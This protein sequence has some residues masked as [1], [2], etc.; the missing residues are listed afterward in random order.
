MNFLVTRTIGYFLTYGLPN[1]WL[2]S[3][4]RFTKMT[5]ITKTTKNKTTQ[6]ATNN[7]SRIGRNHGNHR[8]DKNHRNPGKP[9]VPPK[10]GFEVPE[11][12]GRKVSTNFFRANVEHLHRSGTWWQNP[13]TSHARSLFFPQVSKGANE[14]STEGTSFSMPSPSPERPTPLG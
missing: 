14:L 8:H 10:T 9:R 13:R 2:A 4:S 3:G 11:T 6:T 12:R 5:E 1:V 7:E